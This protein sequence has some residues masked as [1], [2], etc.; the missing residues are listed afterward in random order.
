MLGRRVKLYLVHISQD[1]RDASVLSLY[2]DEVR[3][4]R[5]RTHC[6]GLQTVFM[7]GHPQKTP[8]APAMLGIAGVQNIGPH[9][10]EWR[11][12]S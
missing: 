4:S 5:S 3:R 10:P 9:F 11:D 2:C 1:L 7:A 8:A 12:A 6:L